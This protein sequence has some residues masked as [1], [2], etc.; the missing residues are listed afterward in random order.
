MKKRKIR[1]FSLLFSA[2]LA[3]VVFSFAA[4]WFFAAGWGFNLLSQRH[5]QHILTQWQKGWV[6]HTRKEV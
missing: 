3:A 1:L 6:I 5:W 4:K 2:I